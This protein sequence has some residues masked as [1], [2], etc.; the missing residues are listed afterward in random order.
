MLA[1]LGGIDHIHVYVSNR[2][3]AADWYRDVLGFHVL[4]AFA[5]WAEDKNGPLTIADSS[6][7]IHLALFNSNDFVPS[8]AIAFK[9]DGEG[10]LEW[11]SYLEEQKIMLRC[12]DHQL[13][14]SVYFTDPDK[15]MHE[16][17]TYDYEHVS[18]VLKP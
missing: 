7:Q 14:W 9:T 15:N 6:D 12:S 5:F 1:G 17:T 18:K 10:F 11:K 16:I 8:T 3:Q 4:E 13:A 2:E